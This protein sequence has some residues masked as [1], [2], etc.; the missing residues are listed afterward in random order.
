MKRKLLVSLVVLALLI[1]IAAVA[2]IFLS[3]LN[4]S[5]RAYANVPRIRLPALK[6]EAFAYVSDPTALDNRPTE[7]LLVRRRDASLK[8]W[9]IPTRDG[10][11]FLPDIHWWR[12]GIPCQRFEPDF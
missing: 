2:Q 11:H 5:D 7:L 6:P 8:V 10:I 3:S 12:E 4:P 1:G 9:R